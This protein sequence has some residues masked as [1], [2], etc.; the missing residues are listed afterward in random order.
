MPPLVFLNS[1]DSLNRGLMT[2]NWVLVGSVGKPHGIKGWVKVHSYTEPLTNILLYQPWCLTADDE[3]NAHPAKVEN[4][5]VHNQQLVVK[6]VD[7]QT[8]ESARLLTHHKIYVKRQKFAQLPQQ[9]YYWTDLEGLKVYTC[10]NVY[11]GVVQSLF[12]TGS[13]D[14][15]VVEGEKKYLIPFLLDHTI[16]TI[17]LDQ[18]ILI[19]D[20]D[21]DF[22]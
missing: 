14:V 4:Y 7:Y 19:A 1:R 12:S 3:A 15:L 16:K 2:K 17:D 21:L 8:P 6:F 18:Q 11:L 13:N 9:T 10:E 5:Q 22:A 20:W